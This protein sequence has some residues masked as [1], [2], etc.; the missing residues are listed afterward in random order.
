MQPT[1]NAQVSA[2]KAPIYVAETAAKAF[3]LWQKTDKLTAEFAELKPTNEQM[4]AAIAFETAIKEL[5]ISELEL[6]F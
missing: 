2:P 6:M 3:E 5:F 1:E 4:T